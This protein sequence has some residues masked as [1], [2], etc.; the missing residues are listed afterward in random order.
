M[1]IMFFTLSSIQDYELVITVQK[2]DIRGDAFGKPLFDNDHF[3]DGI[4]E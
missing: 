3:V 1:K 2:S 4:E